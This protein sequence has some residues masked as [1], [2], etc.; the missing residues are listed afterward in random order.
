MRGIAVSWRG[1]WVAGLMLAAAAHAGVEERAASRGRTA[2]AEGDYD[3][4]LELFRAGGAEI[5]VERPR[6]WPGT[7]RSGGAA[8]ILKL[9]SPS[10][11]LDPEAYGEWLWDGT[12][13]VVLDLASDTSDNTRTSAFDFSDLDHVRGGF[14]P[15]D[16]FRELVRALGRRFQE[17]GRYEQAADYFRLAADLRD[18]EVDAAA[19]SDLV[20]LNLERDRLDMVQSLTRE[21]EPRL[22]D[23]KEESFLSSRVE[24]IF[25]YHRTLGGVYTLIEKWG[26]ENT[27]DSAIFQLDKALDFYDRLEAKAPEKAA[28]KYHYTPE[29][30]EQLARAYEATGRLEESYRVRLDAVDFHLERDRQTGVEMFEPIQDREPPPTTSK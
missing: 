26:D 3:Q 24:K 28:A 19:V 30:S 8:Q 27:V 11:D 2:L 23:D 15:A 5:E 6:P 29:L 9:H 25:D 1:I 12:I 18:D 21:Y 20:A 17:Q 13:E 7:G 16:G 22:F 4:A 14:W 10:P